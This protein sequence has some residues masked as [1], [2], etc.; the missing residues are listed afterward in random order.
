MVQVCCYDL[1]AVLQTPRGEVN[2]FYHKH[3]LGVYNFTVYETSSRNGYC[4]AWSEDK[5]KRG[6]NEI[7]SCLW[8]YLT[9]SINHSINEFTNY[10]LF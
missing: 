5:A 4:Y 6:A 10:F 3:K 8:K 7:A 9:N 2:M 1:Q